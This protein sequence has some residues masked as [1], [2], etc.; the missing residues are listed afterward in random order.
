MPAPKGHKPYKGC[1][2]GGRPKEYT[3]EFIEKEA[4]AFLAWLKKPDALYIKRFA[5][6]RGYHPQRLSEF[7]QE[8]KKFAEV[9]NMAQAQQETKLVEG[10]LTNT[11]NAGFTKFVL[12]NKHSKDYKSENTLED[13]S[14]K[15]S[16]SIVIGCHKDRLPKDP[17]ANE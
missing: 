4:D 13:N 9:L 15:F 10:A 3:K 11:F 12:I 14:P 8:N 2:T 16:G 5:L 7:A 17:D 1:E 6:E